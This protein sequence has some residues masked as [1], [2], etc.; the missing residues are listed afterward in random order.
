MTI[1]IHSYAARAMQFVDIVPVDDALGREAGVLLGLTSTADVVDA[2]IV[3]IA[4][5]DDRLLTSDPGDIERLV[6]A[7]GRRIDVV[8]I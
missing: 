4:R 7:S 2:A 1:G 5:D 3:C 8:P 6:A